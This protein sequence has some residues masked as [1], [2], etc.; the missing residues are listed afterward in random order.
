MADICALCEHEFQNFPRIELMCHHSF[1]THCFL[2]NLATVNPHNL[3]FLP[4]RVCEQPVFADDIPND[5]ENESVVT[6]NTVTQEETRINNLWE[7][8]ETFR[9][10]IQSYVKASRKVSKPRVAFKKLVARK[11]LELVPTYTQIKAQYEG[12]YHTKKNEIMSSNEYKSLKS[13]EMR[14][15]RYWSLLRQKYTMT[16]WGLRSLREKRGCKSIHRPSYWRTSPTYIL[17]KALRLRL[18]HW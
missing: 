2:A 14:E 3:H 6:T 16:I 12:L 10:D 17:R 9:K 11:K 1:H 4:C 8:N 5:E 7:T 18:P 13:A 15:Q